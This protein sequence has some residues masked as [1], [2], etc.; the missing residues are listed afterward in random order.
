MAYVQNEREGFQAERSSLQLQ[1]DDESRVIRAF[2]DE[3]KQFETLQKMQSE[4]Q[5]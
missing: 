2:E 5:K 1:L 3:K 4:Q